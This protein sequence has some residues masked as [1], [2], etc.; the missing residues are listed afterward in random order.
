MNDNPASTVTSMRK[1]LTRTAFSWVLR[2]GV[3][4]LLI[5]VT[6][7]SLQGI[8]ALFQSPPPP[9]ERDERPSF[10]PAAAFSQSKLDSGSWQFLDAPFSYS[11]RT[12]PTAQARK[13]FLELPEAD[14]P[15]EFTSTNQSRDLLKLLKSYGSHSKREDF[16]Q[17]SL[18]QLGIQILAFTKPGTSEQPE[19]IVSFRWL[20]PMGEGQ[21]WLITQAP[22]GNSAH[23]SA[24]SVNTSDSPSIIPSQISHRPLAVRT[25]D[26]GKIFSQLILAE[27][28]LPD[29][30]DQLQ[31]NSWKFDAPPDHLSSG[32]VTIYLQRQS[33]AF[34]MLITPADDSTSLR[35]LLLRDD[36]LPP[37]SATNSSIEASP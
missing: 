16:H 12:L 37:S 21:S 10:N 7:W 26:S 24:S 35:I 32:F 13:S 17:Y 9:V 5:W 2:G 31:R 20:I 14:L 18:D 29:L 6:L 34:W 15:T 30:L 25:D 11:A 27:T 19:Q 22:A 33:E 1:P 8:S 4:G 23:S 3:A 36:T 28:T